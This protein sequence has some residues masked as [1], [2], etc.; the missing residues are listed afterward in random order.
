MIE[1]IDRTLE[2]CP[3]CGGKANLYGGKILDYIN[4][5][6]AEKTHSEFWVQTS[7]WSWCIFGNLRARA[8]GVLGG[9]CYRTPEAAVRAWNRRADDE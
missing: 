6:W 8:Y 4:G 7:C 1:H 2:P 9:I 3:F 5:E